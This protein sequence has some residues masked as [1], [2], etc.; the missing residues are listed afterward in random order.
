MAGSN[1]GTRSI[2]PGKLTTDLE[3]IALLFDE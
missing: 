1:H 2:G 3:G